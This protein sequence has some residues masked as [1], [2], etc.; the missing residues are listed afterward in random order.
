MTKRSDQEKKID[1]FIRENFD[2]VL[3]FSWS[4]WHTE[5]RS[6]RYH[7]AS[8][9]A[10]SV[11]VLFF[12]HSD[13]QTYANKPL[14]VEMTNIDGLDVVNINPAISTLRS[15]LQFMSSPAFIQ[16]IHD[17][18]KFR[19]IKKPLIWI[20]D[21]YHY[22]G[23]IEAIPNA[24]RVMHATELYNDESYRADLKNQNLIWDSVKKL[25]NYVDFVVACS[26]GVSDS[27]T[28]IKDF[29]TPIKV[30]AN[31]CDADHIF[32]II[33]EE[34]L[35]QDDINFSEKFLYENYAKSSNKKI[36]IYQGGI[37]PRLDFLLI[38]KLVKSLSEWEF[39]FCGKLSNLK[40]KQ[41]KSLT[42]HPNFKYL[43]CLSVEDLVRNMHESTVGIIPFTQRD[44]IKKSLPLKAYEYIACGLPVVSV[45]ID[46][47]KKEPELIK[48]AIKA[49]SFK[50]AIIDQG[51]TRSN[52]R[53]LHMRRLAAKNNS[54]DKKFSDMVLSLSDKMKDQ[55]PKRKG[56]IAFFYNPTAVHI[57]TIKEH[58][59]AFKK[60]SKNK[61]FYIPGTE[62]YWKKYEATILTA[63]IGDALDRA[64]FDIAI[65]HYS[66][67]TSV[68]GNISGNLVKRL[69][70]FHGMKILFIQD[71]Y[72]GIELSRK[73]MDEINF[74]IVYTTIPKKS[75]EMV[76]PRYRYP[77]TEFPPT[78]TGYAPEYKNLESFALPL[79]ERKISIGYRG[80]PLSAIYG[81]L[82]QEKFN[83]GIDMKSICLKKGLKNIDIEVTEE[84][85]IYG[86]NW[87]AFM[88]S[89]RAT[90]GTESGSNIFDFDGTIQKEIIKLQT[91]EPGI[92]Y[93]EIHKRILSQHEGK[94]SMN[95]VSPKI[96]EAIRLRTVLILF[97]GTYSGVIKPNLHYIPLKKDY[98]NHEDILKKLNDDQYVLRMTNRA[99]DDIISSQ[100]YSYKTFV[101]QFD[102]YIHTRIKLRS[103]NETYS[104]KYFNSDGYFM[105]SRII[106]IFSSSIVYC[107]TTYKKYLSYLRTTYKKYFSYYGKTIIKKYFSLYGVAFVIKYS[108]LYGIKILKKLLPYLKTVI[109]KYFYFSK[110]TKNK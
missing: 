93:N 68:E 41:W 1:P 74:N 87:Y 108:F 81:N 56:R 86:E 73:L 96:F 80:R 50:K 18:L 10:R 88:G 45:P 21:P 8:R 67:R 13:K 110:S 2:A 38:Q 3:I 98:S 9:F 54:Y 102:E 27:L 33:G 95:Q 28:N 83:I 103:D 72:E 99:Y 82:G 84:N 94:I 66:L 4:D 65:I 51:K 7:Y 48:F 11:P 32:E 91:E 52:P 79:N 31:G 49:A 77:I 71:E 16:D 35:E 12:Q 70:K 6:N 64:I 44:L 39:R 30:I 100:K 59:D 17:L 97:E 25:L 20:Y 78:L 26:Q 34:I 62:S 24:F 53:L 89:C 46:E 76:Y 15:L 61:I 104:L 37:N 69:K 22:I 47:L 75:I 43:G 92:S 23:L 101:R 57:S 19:G 105:N 29:K 90:L 5:S 106:H 58:I 107:R 85:R 109:K 36:V 40:D 60:H 42:S 14:N 63:G 55:L